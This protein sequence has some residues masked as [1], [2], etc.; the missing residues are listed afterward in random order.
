LGNVKRGGR[1]KRSKPKAPLAIKLDQFG[2]TPAAVI[3]VICLAVWLVSILKMDDS[4]F[5][6][7]WEGALYHAKVSVA[8]GVVAIP[9]GFPAVI[10]LCLSLGTLRMAQRNV[11]ARKLP[12]VEMLGCTTVI[13]ADK[14]CRQD[15]NAH[16]Q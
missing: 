6:S 1:R 5:A 3:G 10:T 14:M 13:C 4:S 16:Y 2:E 9:D 11:I 8:L 12:S 15:G 7:V